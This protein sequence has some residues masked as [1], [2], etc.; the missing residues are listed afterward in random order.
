MSEHFDIIILGS[1]PGGASIAHRLAPTR[2]G[3]LPVKRVNY[4]PLATI[5]IR[6]EA[7]SLENRIFYDG[8]RV[9]LDLTEANKEAHLRL[10]KKLEGMLRSIGA[11]P[12]LMEQ[13]LYLGKNVPI[14]GIA[15][16]AGTARR[17]PDPKASVLDLDCKAHQ[18]NNLYVADAS[19]FPSIGSVNPTLTIIA[20]ALRVADIIK[21]RLGA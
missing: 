15:H 1:R 21:M 18:I 10:K 8:K 14:G 12:V 19:F 5:Q 13:N 17:G 2:E 9:V 6:R 16:H 11:H 20:Y 4:L 7:L 3:I